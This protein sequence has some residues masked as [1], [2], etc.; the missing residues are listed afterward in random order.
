MDNNDNN[1][2]I[3]KSPAKRRG[4]PRRKYGKSIASTRQETPPQ[5]TAPETEVKNVL[6]EEVTPDLPSARI[7]RSPNKKVGAKSWRPA[8]VLDVVGKD[9]NYTY[10][11]A[12]TS[13]D[14]RV[15][16]LQSEGWERCTTET[17]NLPNKTITDGSK[18]GSEHRIRELI[19]LRMPKDL[20]KSRNEYFQSQQVTQESIKHKLSSELGSDGTNQM[21]YGKVEIS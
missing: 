17:I 13:M 18:M 12:N 2:T 7:Q 1:A 11:F 16:K 21:V 19:L 6:T 20:A 3:E 5:E 8:S 9:P 15:E 10:R 14:G 4:R